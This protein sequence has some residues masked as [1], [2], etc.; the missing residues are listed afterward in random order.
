MKISERNSQNRYE[1]E[2]MCTF[3]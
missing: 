3:S 2:F 1:F